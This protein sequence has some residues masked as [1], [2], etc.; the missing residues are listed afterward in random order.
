MSEHAVVRLC[1]DLAAWAVL[2]VT[3][4]MPEPVAYRGAVL[5]TSLASRTTVDLIRGSDTAKETER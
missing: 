5:A 2:A 1:R 4:R 3:D